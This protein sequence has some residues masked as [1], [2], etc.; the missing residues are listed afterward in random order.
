MHLIS[1]SE[2]PDLRRVERIGPT[3]Y[4]PTDSPFTVMSQYRRLRQSTLS[5]LREL[6]ND[7]W[8][9][10]G[11][12]VDNVTVT[13]R[14]LALELVDHDAEIMERIDAT[15]IARGA[16]PDAVRPLVTT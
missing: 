14:D 5:L 4:D 13:L 10:A 7:A 12:D 3:E 16:L 2:F 6:P 8:K 11:T 1:V 15:L 9:R